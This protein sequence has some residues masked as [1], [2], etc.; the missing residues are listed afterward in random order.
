MKYNR[1]LDWVALGLRE[2]TVNDNPVLAAR[3]FAKAGTESDVLAA[4][5]VIETT[6]SFH[7]AKVEAAKAAAPVKADAMPPQFKAK[8][9]AEEDGEVCAEFGED[10]LDDVSDEEEAA[11]PAMP[12]GA[13]KQMASVL[14]KMERA[15][16]AK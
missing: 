6:N 13:A 14:S 12:M 4:I 9:E 5:S 1:A 8:D 10:P 3:L 11:P 2:L 16:T 15:R 7:H